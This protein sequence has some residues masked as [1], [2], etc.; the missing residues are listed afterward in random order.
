MT[1]HTCTRKWWW[2]V[3]H[4]TFGAQLLSLFLHACCGAKDASCVVFLQLA[5]TLDNTS[6]YCSVAAIMLARRHSARERPSTR[7]ETSSRNK[8]RQSIPSTTSEDEARSS[9]SSYA[10]QHCYHYQDA[11]S[12]GR[13]R[14]YHE[15]VHN[16]RWSSCLYCRILYQ[17]IKVLQPSFLASAATPGSRDTLRIATAGGPQGEVGISVQNGRWYSRE[18]TLQIYRTEGERRLFLIPKTETGELLAC[19]Y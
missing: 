2:L 12:R 19:I 8:R 7:D 1:K 17:A 14:P 4:D 18:T 10:C 5:T 13:R 11:S 3:L 16:L 6:R 9:L 15:Y